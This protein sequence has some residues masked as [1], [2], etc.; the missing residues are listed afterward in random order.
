MMKLCWNDINNDDVIFINDT[1]QPQIWTVD[2]G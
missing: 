2:R 1:Q